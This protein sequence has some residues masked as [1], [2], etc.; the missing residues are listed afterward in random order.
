M[1]YFLS[2]NMIRR[3]QSPLLKNTCLNFPGGIRI[4]ALTAWLLIGLT[5]H[6]GPIT[7]T[8]NCLTPEKINPDPEPKLERRAFLS[9]IF[10]TNM[11]SSRRSRGKMNIFHFFSVSALGRCRFHYLEYPVKISLLRHNRAR[12]LINLSGP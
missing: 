3:R 10:F 9:S 6:R 7:T 11:A 5:Q 12:E 4:S 8:C 2:F 1:Y